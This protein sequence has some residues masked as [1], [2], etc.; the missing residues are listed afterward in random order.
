MKAGKFEWMMKVII[1][2]LANHVINQPL[3][4]LAESHTWHSSITMTSQ[5]L[6]TE[7]R[8]TALLM[9]MGEPFRHRPL[10]LLERKDEEDRSL[11]ILN[12][13]IKSLNILRCI[14]ENTSFR[15]CAD[16]GANRLHD[17]LEEAS[18]SLKSKYVGHADS[19]R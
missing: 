11:I 13:P 4:R 8:S 17:F 2:S 10:H 12:Q 7:Y 1:V 16:G 14:W 3:L 19:T 6:S 15:I 9:H 18:P 5:R